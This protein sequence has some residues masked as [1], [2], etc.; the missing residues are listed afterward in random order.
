MLLLIALLASDQSGVQKEASDALQDLASGSHH[1]RYAIM[2]AGAV[3]LLVA[4]LRSD[5]PVVQM[6][7]IGVLEELADGSDERKDA[8]VAAGAVPLLGIALSNFDQPDVHQ[9]CK[10]LL[11]ATLHKRVRLRLPPALYLCSLAC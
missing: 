9:L 1:D 3:P 10:H 6:A 11:H 7:A 8:I 5:Q 2:A 4:L